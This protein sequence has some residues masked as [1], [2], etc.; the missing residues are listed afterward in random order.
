M[1]D[2]L[3]NV[4]S[5]ASIAIDSSD[6]SRIAYYYDQSAGLRYASHDG[7]SWS[8]EDIDTS[9]Q[10]SRIVLELDDSD[11]PRIAYKD[12]NKEPWL[13]YNNSGT[14]DVWEAVRVRNGYDLGG[15]MAMTLDYSTGTA[16]MAYRQYQ[17]PAHAGLVSSVYTGTVMATDPV[18][19]S[20]DTANFVGMGPEIH[21]AG[22]TVLAPFMNGTDGA[23]P[24]YV[25]M[26]TIRAPGP[27]I[28]TVDGETYSVEATAYQW[29]WTRQGTSTL[30]LQRKR[31]QPD[32]RLV[33]RH[34]LAS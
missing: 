1:V 14:D 29:P 30:L 17:W 23:S 24:A 33:R 5:W 2:S 13:A 3:Y 19:D 31:V 8:F 20:G 25:E 32:V 27:T 16:Y 12:G 18:S 15:H 9:L 11:R 10:N 7:S 26:A 4:G 28:T 6:L 34:I 21:I 22:T